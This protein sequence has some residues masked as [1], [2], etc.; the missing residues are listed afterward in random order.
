MCKLL[1]HVL[2]CRI[3]GVFAY[4]KDRGATPEKE[5]TTRCRGQ[6]AR[7]VTCANFASSFGSFRLAVCLPTG[8][9]THEDQRQREGTT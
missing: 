8:G 2:H 9:G 3:D 4:A 5:R 1:L 6:P 7:K